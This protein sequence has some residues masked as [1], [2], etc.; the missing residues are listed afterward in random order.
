MAN[1][2]NSTIT[3]H[4]HNEIT[5]SNQLPARKITNNKQFQKVKRNE[6][7]NTCTIPHIYTT[8]KQP[9]LLQKKGL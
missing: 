2:K 8:T 1:Y 4:E 5:H 6:N 9:Y 7:I 3:A